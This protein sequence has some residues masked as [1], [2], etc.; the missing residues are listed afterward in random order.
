MTLKKLLIFT[1]VFLSIQFKGYSNESYVY[2]GAK[3]FGYGI[4]TSDL[5]ELNTSLIALGFT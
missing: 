1:F 3:I 5:Q 4:E 2:G